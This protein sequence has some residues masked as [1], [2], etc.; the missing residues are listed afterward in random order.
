MEF[1]G[2]ARW[3]IDIKTKGYTT[4]SFGN[5]EDSESTKYSSLPCIRSFSNIG[6]TTDELQRSAN[7]DRVTFIIRYKGD[8][9]YNDYVVFEGG[10]YK[11]ESIQEI[12]YREYLRIITRREE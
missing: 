12:A 1:A 10:E 5:R 3:N 2:K 9:T 11:I 6:L 4:G 7:L 8:I